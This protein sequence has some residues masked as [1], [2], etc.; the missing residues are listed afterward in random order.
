[1]KLFHSRKSSMIVAVDEP[2]MRPL[3][4]MTTEKSSSSDSVILEAATRAW[5][6][7]SDEGLKLRRAIRP[8]TQLPPIHDGRRGGKGRER[9]R[10]E[11]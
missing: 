8:S 5:T 9:G 1:M 7:A 3:E 2:A 11:A 6:D 10:G 4:S